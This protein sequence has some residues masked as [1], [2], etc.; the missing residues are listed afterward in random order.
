MLRQAQHAAFI[1]QR[2]K[3]PYFPD[4]HIGITADVGLRTGKPL[5]LNIACRLFTL[6]NRLAGLPHSITTQLFVIYSWHFDVN[7][8]SIKQ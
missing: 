8:D 7:V 3:S 5:L 1:L 4:T 6:A 2:A